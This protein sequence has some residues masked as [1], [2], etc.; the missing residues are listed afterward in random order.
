MLERTADP[1]NT[2]RQEVA[3]PNTVCNHKDAC[4]SNE[5]CFIYIISRMVKKGRDLMHCGDREPNRE[6]EQRECSYHLAWAITHIPEQ[7]LHVDS[8]QQDFISA[9]SDNLGLDRN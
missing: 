8:G 9:V 2:L 6:I 1:I 5:I 4:T 7:I 3:A